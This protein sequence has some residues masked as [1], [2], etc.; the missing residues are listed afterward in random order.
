MF[1]QKVNPTIIFRGAGRGVWTLP[2]APT[3]PVGTHFGPYPGERRCPKDYHKKGEEG[4]SGYAWQIFDSEEKRK[5]V[6]FVDPGS[7][8]HESNW[9]AMVNSAVRRGYFVYFY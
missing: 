5:V 9:M 6:A 3:I 4:E 2:T 1:D 8:P 7:N